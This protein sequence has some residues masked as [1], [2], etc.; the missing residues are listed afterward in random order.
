MRN[1]KNEYARKRQ[2]LSEGKCRECGNINVVRSFC[3]EKCY[4]IKIS[5]KRLGS[6][7]Y[8][9]QIKEIL[10]NQ[11]YKCALTGDNLTFSNME[12]DHIIPTS[13]IEI[14][15]LLNV[16]WVTKEANRMKQ[17]LTDEELIVLINK[18]LTIKKSRELPKG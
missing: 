13:R 7:K 9:K 18:V 8:W 6:G 2:W 5:S 1:R 16:R 17:N 14:N 4:L 12:L 11:K 15:D 3:C 10:I